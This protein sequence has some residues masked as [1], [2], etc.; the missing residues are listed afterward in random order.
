MI[1]RV[2]IKLIIVSCLSYSG[3]TLAVNNP[4]S[5]ATVVNLRTACIEGGVE[6]TNCFDEL[7]SLE[8]WMNSI[9][10]ASSLLINV[11]PGNFTR[12]FSGVITGALNCST[13]NITIKGSGRENSHIQTNFGS[14]PSAGIHINSGCTNLDV[15]DIKISGWLQGAVVTELSAIT[16]WTNVELSGGNYGWLESGACP[17][18][19]GKHTW[20]S[21]RIIATGATGGT[22]TYTA[23]CAQSWFWGSQIVSSNNGVGASSS[24]ALQATQAEIHL[25]GSNVRLIVAN[26]IDAE[27]ADVIRSLNNSEIH[28]HGTGLDLTHNGTGAVS[29]LEADSSSMIHANESA[30]SLHNNGTGTVSRLT[31]NGKISAPYHWGGKTTPPGISSRSGADTYIEID[32]PVADDCSAGGTFPHTMVYRAECTGSGA[33]EGPWYDTV[34]N[35][36]RK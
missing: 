34:T 23:A 21:S 12:G 4:P 20:F 15:Q 36:C 17:N 9:R 13:A 3:V 10:S 31:G 25:Y 1:L 35:L 19:D 7:N 30:F 33:D 24:Y 5:N 6:V 27:G 16:S 32:C 14:F 29:F 18:N 28:I 26:G 2:C 22:I 8:N 11:G